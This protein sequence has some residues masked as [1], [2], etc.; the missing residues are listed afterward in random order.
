LDR[1]LFSF[2]EKATGAL[3]VMRLGLS[4]FR[5]RRS[6]KRW[7]ITLLA[8]LAIWLL[9]SV[10]VAY[11]LT[12]RRR[13]QFDEPAPQTAWG[14]VDGYRVKT[15]D[16][17]ELGAWFVDSHND[18]ASVLL[19]HGNNGSRRNSLSR[20]EVLASHGYA[21][22]MVSLRAHGDSTGEYHDV[23]FGARQDVWAA[24]EFLEAHRAGRPV[25]IIGTSMGSAAAVFAADK[26]DHRVAGYILESPYQDLKVAVWNRTDVHL[27]PG[28]SHA[29]YL[30]L[31]VVS[32]LFVP[33]L[34]RISPLEAISG[35]PDDVPV[36][37]LA[38]DADRLARPE[39]AKA[40]YHK[41]ATHGSLLLIP[42]AGHGDLFGIAPELYSHTVL[43][44]CRQISKHASLSSSPLVPVPR[45]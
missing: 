31:R 10:T 8:V 44:F 6:I 22:L 20:A 34:D 1:R 2:C 15:S 39:E 25:I 37:I 40:L 23:G 21:V 43:E 4:L 19:L 42:G 30:G 16:G 13:P 41:V 36:L 24:V 32:P 7:S 29:A 14:R 3:I 38:G 17:E 35:I 26:L 28:L 11:L 12:G 18:S 9:G 33:H 45:D 5:S 27:P